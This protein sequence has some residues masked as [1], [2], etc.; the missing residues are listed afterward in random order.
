MK[1]SG[2]L[3]SFPSSNFW[4]TNSGGRAWF[5]TR[6][7]RILFCNPECTRAMKSHLGYKGPARILWPMLEGTRVVVEYDRTSG[8]GHM[9]VWC[10]KACSMSILR[11]VSQAKSTLKVSSRLGYPLPHVQ[12]N[13]YNFFVQQPLHLFHH[14]SLSMIQESP[15]QL[16]RSSL[17]MSGSGIFM[18]RA[19]LQVKQFND[20]RNLAQHNLI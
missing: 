4:G 19:S 3:Y 1:L 16:H 13:L 5:G 15:N 11:C 9:A 17:N 18:S 20:T 7:R 14:V 8:W 2:V 6:K 12:L 10:Y